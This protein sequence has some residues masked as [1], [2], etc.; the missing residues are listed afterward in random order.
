MSVMVVQIVSAQ[1]VTKAVNQDYVSNSP[2]ADNNFVVAITD[3]DVGA[4]IAD[5]LMCFWVRIFCTGN[6][7]KQFQ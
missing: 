5:K 3:T 6:R 2:D 7:S 4:T 1:V